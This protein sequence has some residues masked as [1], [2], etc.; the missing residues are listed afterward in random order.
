MADWRERL[1]L[2]PA[3]AYEMSAEGMA[4]RRIMKGLGSSVK[5][6]GNLCKRFGIPYDEEDTTFGR[7]VKILRETYMTMAF[8][9]FVDVKA[10]C[11]LTEIIG[12]LLEC[13]NRTGIVFFREKDAHDITAFVVG[14]NIMTGP[15]GPVVIRPGAK[16]QALRDGVEIWEQ[17]PVRLIL[18]FSVKSGQ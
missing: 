11:S 1:S 9:D 18:S 12:E 5:D 7:A 17:D 8:V 3:A 13:T 4:A 10:G 16:F 15:L 6:I 14:K 2:S